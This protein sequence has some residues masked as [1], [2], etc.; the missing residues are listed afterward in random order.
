MV[1]RYQRYSGRMKLLPF[2]SLLLAL[3]LSAQ[4]NPAIEAGR[5]DIRAILAAQGA[6]GMSVAVAVDGK[7]VWSE[8]FGLADVEQNVAATGATRYRLGSVSKLFTAAIAAR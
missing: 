5:A 8:G 4:T 7:I 2:V 6:P 3:S 1:Q